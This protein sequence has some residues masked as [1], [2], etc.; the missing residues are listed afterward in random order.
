MICSV[1]KTASFILD[2][3]RRDGMKG[4]YYNTLYACAAECY[5]SK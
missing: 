4:V 3:Y 2:Y 1:I 5:Q